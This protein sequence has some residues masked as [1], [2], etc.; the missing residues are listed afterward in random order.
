MLPQRLI[1]QLS[2]CLARRLLPQGRTPSFGIAILVDTSLGE[3][4]MMIASPPLS[5]SRDYS[6]EW[7]MPKRT[8]HKCGSPFFVPHSSRAVMASGIIFVA[9]ERL[10]LTTGIV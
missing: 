5:R 6:G 9:C 10:S 7:S 4:H 2:L 8:H 3:S 1:D